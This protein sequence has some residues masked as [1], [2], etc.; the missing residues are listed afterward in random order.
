MLRNLNIV[1]PSSIP[2]IQRFKLT[3]VVYDEKA[4][5]NQF[6]NFK[7][8][9]RGSLISYVIPAYLRTNKGIPLFIFNSASC[10]SNV[11]IENISENE[12]CSIEIV[13]LKG[14]NLGD[15]TLN[16]NYIIRFS[17][18]SQSVYISLDLSYNSNTTEQTEQSTDDVPALIKDWQ[19]VVYYFFTKSCHNYTLTI[20]NMTLYYT[21]NQP[22]TFCNNKTITSNGLSTT[23]TLT[24][25]S[26]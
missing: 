22:K 26:S 23:D 21:Y 20:T 24:N 5:I 10:Q 2:I 8:Q 14:S 4:F 25:S 13:L 16:D 17:E 1:F 12:I 18:C 7:L 15:F 9:I 6:S 19:L 3:N 11:I